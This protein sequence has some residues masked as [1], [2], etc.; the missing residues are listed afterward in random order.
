M[1]T[2]GD[3]SGRH[4]LMISYFFP[5]LGGGGVFRTL[6]FVKY[7]PDF[8]WTP[9]VIAA[10]DPSYWHHDP[11]LL[12]DLPDGIDVRRV[13]A[14]DIFSKLT[15]HAK[16][17]PAGVGP[18]IARYTEFPDH[19]FMW[20]Q[21]AFGA[22]L[23]LLKSSKSKV[24]YS[25]ATPWS[26]HLLALRLKRKTGIPWVADFRDEWADNPVLIGLDAKLLGRHKKAE[27]LVALEADHLIFA[28]Q[29]V[30]TAFS[31]KNSVSP[32]KI[33]VIT[34]GYDEDDFNS[35]ESA[36]PCDGE[37]RISHIGRLYPTQSADFLAKA[38]ERHWSFDCIKD[39]PVRL[40]FLGVL[41]TPIKERTGLRIEIIEQASHAAALKVLQGSHVALLLVDP[42]RGAGNIPGKT[43]EYLASGRRLLALVPPG[44]AAERMVKRAGAGNCADP[45]DG[46][47]IVSA[48]KM[49]ARDVAHGSALP[50]PDLD[51]ISSFSRKRLT[52]RLVRIF[53]SIVSKSFT[54]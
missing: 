22:C 28:H 44:G 36:P 8:G 35:W 45:G 14:V 2:T 47:A 29:D 12:A 3:S 7:L 41:D 6:K 15:F 23:S 30:A 17:L 37:V 42:D 31:V 32:K 52:G 48:I 21:R 53:D 9:H 18:L 43:F 16:R 49:I 1:M 24:I 40:Q 46:A 25:S 38:L 27:A 51:F 26:A 34:N 54:G 4:V 13:N 11:G 19:S 5:P 39:I 10:N 33:T 50:E 20:A